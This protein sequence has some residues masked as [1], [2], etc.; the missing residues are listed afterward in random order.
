MKVRIIFSFLIVLLS[1]ASFIQA[2]DQQSNLKEIVEKMRVDLNLTDKQAE[3]V[4]TIIKSNTVKIESFFKSIEDEPVF[5]QRNVQ[6]RMRQLREEE[7]IELSKVLTEEQMN[8]VITKQKMRDR[9]NRDQINF[10]ESLNEGV[11]LNPSGGAFQF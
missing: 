6:A 1:S 7:N 4:K 8:K 2:K 10:A 3:K 11:V 9:L 5:N